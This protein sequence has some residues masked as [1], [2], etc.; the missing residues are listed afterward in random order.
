MNTWVSA[1]KKSKE[2]QKNCGGHLAKP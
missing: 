2:G 1:E